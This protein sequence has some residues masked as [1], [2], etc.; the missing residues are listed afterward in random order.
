MTKF[1]CSA[2]AAE[3][4]ALEHHFPFATILISVF[5]AGS[6]ASAMLMLIAQA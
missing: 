2:D 3:T 5:M 6:V 1:S 4:Y